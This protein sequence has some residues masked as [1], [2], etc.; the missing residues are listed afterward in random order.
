MQAGSFGGDWWKENLCLSHSTFTVICNKLHPI[1]QR[2]NTNLRFSISVEK[3]V[4][5][6]VWKLLTNVEHSEL[7]GIGR[8]TACKKLHDTCQQIVMD[9]LP[10]M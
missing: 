10:N 2:N 8:S 9:L 3:R 6:T 1:I 4:T 5:I 7:F